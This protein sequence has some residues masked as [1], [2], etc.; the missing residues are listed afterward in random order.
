VLLTA[1]Y[2][3]SSLRELKNIPLFS[4]DRSITEKNKKVTFIPDL[5][6]FSRSQADINVIHILGHGLDEHELNALKSCEL[7]FHPAPVSGFQSVNW[8]N[9]MISG[10]KLT[11]Q[12]NFSIGSK[13]TVKILLRGLSTTL[14]SVELRGTQTFELS[15]HPK[16]IDKAVYYLLALSGKDTLAHEKIPVII[17]EKAPLRILMLS[18]SPGFEVKFLKNWLFT[19]KYVLSVRTNISKDKFST[20]FLNTERS[21]LTRVSPAL[22]EN[23]DIIIGDVAEL[24]R[25]GAAENAAI[26]SQVSKGLGL[27]ILADSAGGAGFYR[28]AFTVRQNRAIGQK[29]LILNWAGQTAQ[30]TSLPAGGSMDIVNRPGEQALVRDNAN[31]VLVSSRLY[32]AGRMVVSTLSDTYTWMLTNNSFD[33]SSYWSHILEHAARKAEVSESWAVLEQYPVINSPAHIRIEGSATNIPSASVGNT[34]LNFA[35]DVAHSY[36]WSAPYWPSESGWHTIRSGNKESSWY[37]YDKNDWVSV[38]AV[39]KAENTAR[40]INERKNLVRKAEGVAGTYL[41]RVPAIWFYI[42]FLLSMGYL[43]WEGKVRG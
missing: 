5:E 14:D 12:G 15:T 40:F 27:V 37:V 1:G 24:S 29:S 13:K 3:K 28:R 19:E 22:L 18:S 11:V 26:Q 36:R 23:I 7:I 2:E 38:R 9:R 4:T 35:Q 20:E 16:L 31:H 30:K 42:L 10:D 8:D 21:N 32:G 25:L 33:Y 6:Y 43:W 17:D 34:P 41:Y 39:E